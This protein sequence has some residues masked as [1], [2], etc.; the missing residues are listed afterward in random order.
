VVRIDRK[1][2]HHL[3]CELTSHQLR[4]LTD[5]NHARGLPGQLIQIRNAQSARRAIGFEK[6]QYTRLA[7][8]LTEADLGRFL[9]GFDH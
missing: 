4:I 8:R 1:S 7:R 5:P 6:D 9:S 2:R 3:F